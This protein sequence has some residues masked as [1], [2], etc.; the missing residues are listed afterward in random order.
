MLLEVQ[1][2]SAA[3]ANNYLTRVEREVGDGNHSTVLPEFLED[4]R[5]R[6][7]HLAARALMVLAAHAYKG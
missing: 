5:Q 4:I 1:I 3:V 6:H 7:S 2:W